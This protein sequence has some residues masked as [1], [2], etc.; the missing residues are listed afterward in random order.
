MDATATPAAAAQPPAAPPPASP[1][2]PAAPAA[3]SALQ[4]AGTPDEKPAEKPAE[5]AKPVEL[6]APKGLELHFESLTKQA[7][8]LGLEGEKAQKYLDSLAS[9][10]AARSKQLDEALAAQDARWAAELKA[11]PEIGGPKFDAAMK[12]ARRALARFGG[13][14]AEGQQ[15][16]PLAALLHQAGLGNNPLVLKAFAAIGRALADDSING[17]AKAAPAAGARKSDAELFYET[18]TAAAPKE[19]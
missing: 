4:A 11:D 8:E 16:A 18:P 12:D 1:A 3:A 14:P 13:K 9:I 6:K 7:K 2:A 15:V 10:D 17:T 5:A 19:Q